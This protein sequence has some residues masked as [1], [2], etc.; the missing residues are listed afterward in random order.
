VEAGTEEALADAGGSSI[1]G[2]KE[3]DMTVDV[4]STVDREEK[5]GGA[6]FVTEAEV[7]HRSVIDP[8]PNP[9]KGMWR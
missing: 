7:L 2:R 1:Y 5:G 9:E 6:P 4:Q 3:M 8:C